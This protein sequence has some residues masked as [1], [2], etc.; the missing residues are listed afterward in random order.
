MQQAC[1]EAVILDGHWQDLGKSSLVHVT[2]VVVGWT[3]ACSK[4]ANMHQ[5]S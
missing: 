1:K 3:Y 4:G 2:L 5:R